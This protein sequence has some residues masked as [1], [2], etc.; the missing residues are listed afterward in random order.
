MEGGDC[1]KHLKKG[2]GTEK[3]E[4][5]TNILKRGNKLGQ[6]LGALKR[7]RAGTPLRTMSQI[8]AI[9]SSAI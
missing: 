9:K 3:R 2:G 5:E 1:I 7:G 6:G 4:G 8:S